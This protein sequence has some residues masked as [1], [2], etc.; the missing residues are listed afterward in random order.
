MRILV[1]GGAGFIGS[2]LVDALIRDGHKVCVVDN[3][4]TGKKEYE[5][6]MATYI[7]MDV[8]SSDLH[9]AFRDFCPEVVYHLAAQV[10]VETSMANPLNDQSTNIAGCIN[11]LECCKEFDVKKIIYSS[12]AAVYGSPSY[13][14]IDEKHATDPKSFYGISKLTPELYIKLYKELYQLEYTIL[15]YGNVFGPRQAYKGEAGVVSIFIN[16]ALRG[17][18]ICF[19]GSGNQTRDF[20]YVRD[21]VSANLAA[22]KQGDGRVLNISRNGPLSLIELFNMIK[23][24]TNTELKSIHASLREGDIKDSWLDNSLAKEALNWQPEVSM[25]DGLKQTIDYYSIESA[26]M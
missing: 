23:N 8:T 3:Y 1:T 21:I 5:N 4:T 18:R 16:K 9:L 7:T 15:R 24:I 19:H 6:I 26:A 10:D 2:N 20:I 25:I 12:T 22:L 11:V 17:E 14:P 13:L